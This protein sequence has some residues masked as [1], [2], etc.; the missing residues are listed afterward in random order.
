MTIGIMVHELVQ[1]ALT[2][3]ISD[4]TQLRLEADRMIRESIQMLYDA[5]MT[6]E[7]TRTSMQCYIQPLNDFMKSYVVSK[8]SH[9][10]VS[11]LIQPNS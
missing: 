2:Q 10:I 1:K 6:E 9:G 11:N 3:Q 7:E 8:A 4:I 5:G